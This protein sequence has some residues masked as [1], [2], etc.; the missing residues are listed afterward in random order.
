MQPSCK[1]RSFARLGCL[2]QKNPPEHAADMNVRL[3][4]TP[5]AYLLCVDQSSY[6]H[7]GLDGRAIRA[8]TLDLV[9]D[10]V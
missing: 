5:A 6:C 1:Y 3:H 9:K 8:I 7:A 2:S 4:I 10:L